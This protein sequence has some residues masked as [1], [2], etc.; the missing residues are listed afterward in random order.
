MATF[1]GDE[2]KNWKLQYFKVPA[3]KI[4]LVSQAAGSTDLD[5]VLLGQIGRALGYGAGSL[6]LEY[7]DNPR[8]PELHW[9]DVGRL[10]TTAPA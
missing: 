1:S 3:A 5:A 2:P 6:M 8:G 9:L 4:D 7:Q 10:V